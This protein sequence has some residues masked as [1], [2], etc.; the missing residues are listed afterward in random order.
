MPISLNALFENWRTKKIGA[1]ERLMLIPV[2]LLYEAE[3]I[4]KSTADSGV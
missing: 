3:L 1:P 2:G 4:R